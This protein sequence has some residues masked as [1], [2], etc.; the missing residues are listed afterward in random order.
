MANVYRSISDE[1]YQQIVDAIPLIAILIGGADDNFDDHEK[2]WAK[3]IVHIR[4]F[5]NDMELKPIYQDLEPVFEEK[6]HTFYK[7]L[8]SNPEER[9][10]EISKRLSKLNSILPKLKISIASRIYES[11]I[12][13]AEQVAKASGGF[14]RMLSVSAEES[15]WIGLPMLDP[16][17]FM[18]EEE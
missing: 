8:P 15:V 14:L 13:F 9:G 4:T 18:D 3:K 2:E 16:I 12:E 7:G 11:F 5:A 17:F 6:I 10:K 1:E